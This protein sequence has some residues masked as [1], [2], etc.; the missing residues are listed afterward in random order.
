MKSIIDFLNESYSNKTIVKL[1]EGDTISVKKLNINYFEDFYI[2]SKEKI[3]ISNDIYA[4]EIRL[5]NSYDKEYKNFKGYKLYYNNTNKTIIGV[6]DLNH[7]KPTHKRIGD[8]NI[9]FIECNNDIYILATSVDKN[10]KY[11]NSSDFNK[12]K[13]EFLESSKD[14]K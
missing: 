3:D 7:N 6:S 10:K 12:N 4:Y 5:L 14:L 2:E 8:P 9:L 1:Q 13:N 11:I